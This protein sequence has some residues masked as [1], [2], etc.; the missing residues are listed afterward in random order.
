M[1]L[2][3]LMPHKNIELL[4]LACS[5]TFDPG[6]TGWTNMLLDQEKF[7]NMRGAELGASGQFT[8]PAGKYLVTTI[9]HPVR[10]DHNKATLYNVS[11]TAYVEEAY[12]NSN[13]NSADD[14]I[15]ADQN[16]GTFAFTITSPK[17]FE[18]HIQFTTR[19][20]SSRIGSGGTTVGPASPLD[21]DTFSYGE[22]LIIR[23]D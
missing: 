20:T 15:G 3:D 2:T 9:I 10:S 11:D 23:H 19:N 18:M 22:V 8:L 12:C 5:S 14:G 4:K 6:S 17:V 7:N 13:W 21:Q 1:N 16:V